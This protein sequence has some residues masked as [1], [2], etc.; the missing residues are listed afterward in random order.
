MHSTECDGV[1]AGAAA[2]SVG[3]AVAVGTGQELF[4]SPLDQWS[5]RFSRAAVAC[6]FS[7]TG[8]ALC[9]MPFPLQLEVR[10]CTAFTLDLFLIDAQ[11]GP[12]WKNQSTCSFIQSMQLC[13][14]SPSS[15]P[16]CSSAAIPMAAPLCGS[17]ERFPLCLPV[18]REV[19]DIRAGSPAFLL[20]FP[21]A[22][23]AS[24]S[25]CNTH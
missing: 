24:L 8:V 5:G 17:G 21:P 11:F 16:L 4:V 22:S 9:S 23:A 7:V 10:V 2:G 6:W 3:R 15:N 12:A 19:D 25:S 14:L 13:I 20:H 18:W 1:R